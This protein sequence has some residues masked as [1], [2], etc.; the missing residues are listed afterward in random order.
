MKHHLID[1]VLPFPPDQVFE[2]FSVAEIQ[3]QWIPPQG[4]ECTELTTECWV[5]GK[6]TGEFMDADGNRSHWTGTFTEVVPGICIEYAFDLTGMG[7][8]LEG[9]VNR[10]EFSPV[11]GGTKVSV[12]LTTEI[13]PLAEGAS[14]GWGQSLD[15][16]EALLAS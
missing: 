15:K 13:A 8:T 12:Y 14:I 6:T 5:G 2:A 4:F 9:L 3:R 11:D 16:L 7:Q 10:I 1:R